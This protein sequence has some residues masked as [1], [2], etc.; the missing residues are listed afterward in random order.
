[1]TCKLLAGDKVVYELEYYSVGGGF[2][3]WKGYTA[4]QEG[5]AE[6]PV[7]DDEGAA[8]ARRGQQA[9]D[10]AGHHGQRGGGLRQD[11]GG[12]QRL[13]RQDPR[14]D[15]GHREVGPRRQGGRP[16]RPDQAPLEGRHRLQAGHGRQVPG[17]PRH[18]RSC[19]RTPSPGRRRTPAATW[20]SPRRPAARPASC[21][22]SSTRSARAGARCR[23]R[24][25]G[26]GSS[27]ARRSA[28]CAST[29]R[30]CPAPRAAARPRS[31]SPRRWRPRSSPRRTTAR[32]RWSRTPRSRPSSTT[33][34]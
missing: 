21:P 19:P 26:R 2:I 25:S 24:R 13:H 8:Q 34:A 18:R 17:R 32:R 3:E 27:P 23:R 11:R 7:R 20:S 10:R 5:A 6:V 16:A 14:R 9:L 30:P 28:T 15:G 33:S 22:R 1:M 31:A 12:D 4:A 29:T